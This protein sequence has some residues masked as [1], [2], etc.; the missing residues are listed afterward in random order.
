MKENISPPLSKKGR[1]Q[2]IELLRIVA[3]FGIVSYHA[4]APL[5]DFNYAGLVVFLVLSPYVDCAHNWDK[6]RSFWTL[7]KSYLAPWSFWMMVYAAVNMVL[8]RPV[9][10]TGGFPHNLL[11]GTSPHLWFMP[12][13]F[14]VL[15][16]I[17][18]LKSWCGPVALFWAAAIGATMLLLTV[19]IWRPASVAWGPPFSQWMHA[20]P[21]VLFGIA[22]GLGNRISRPWL[23]LAMS[24]LGAGL[25][26]TVAVKLPGV[27][28]TYFLG[29]LLVMIAIVGGN[30]P[31]I[32]RI[33]LRPA[34]SCMLGVYLS[35]MLWLLFYGK[36]LGMGSYVTAF[37]AF[38]FA[39]ASVWIM[40]RLTPWSEIALGPRYQLGS[41]GP[42]R[43]GWAS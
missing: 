30:V 29:I 7:C 11:Y 14:L 21:A 17:N 39:W 28:M 37:L 35:H 9:F 2:G 41:I 3:A 40:Q 27:S 23:I 10:A 38:L 13:M 20:T 26:V 8:H 16:A 36:L 12:A 15:F 5:H 31:F 1:N 32:A 42:R 25:A 33:D 18:R 4:L 24:A 6:P 43:Q 34:S 22:L 19:T